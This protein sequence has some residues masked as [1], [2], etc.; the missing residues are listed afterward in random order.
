MWLLQNKLYNRQTSLALPELN[1]LEQFSVGRRNW[2]SGRD[3]IWVEQSPLRPSTLRTKS[4]GRQV[5]GH[6]AT[7]AVLWRSRLSC[8]NWLRPW[9]GSSCPQR[10]WEATNSSNRCSDSKFRCHFDWRACEVRSCWSDSAWKRACPAHSRRLVTENVEK[11]V[12]DDHI[13]AQL[14]PLG[15][16]QIVHFLVDF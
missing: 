14:E 12:T 3:P 9:P 11:R 15:I 7:W 10:T 16:D 2:T 8:F 1:I 6:P 5:D 4:A 13:L